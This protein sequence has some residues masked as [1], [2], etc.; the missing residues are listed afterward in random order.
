LAKRTEIR[1][2]DAPT[3]ITSKSAPYVLWGDKTSG[4][5]NDL[6]YVLSKQIIMV[7]VF[8]PPGAQFRASEAYRPYYDTHECLYV[9]EGQYTCH[10]P[11]TG[12]VRT[13]RQ[14]EMIF[15]PEKRWHYGVN[16]GDGGLRLLEVIAPPT[17]QAAS[18]HVPIPAKPRS[19]D[20]AALAA[21]PI[22]IG[23]GAQNLHVRNESNAVNCLLSGSLP[24]W[25]Q[26]FASTERAS[27]AIAKLFPNQYSHEVTFAHDVAYTNSR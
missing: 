20:D 3:L 10:D 2:L 9:L 22:K 4:F 11:H 8:L 27:F 16:Y 12:E 18:A 17:S 21:L 23:L 6:F 7:T 25:C 19:I 26:V 24:V 15:M 1:A 5:V 14:G 13:A